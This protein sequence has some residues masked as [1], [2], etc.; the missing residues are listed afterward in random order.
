MHRLCGFARGVT[1]TLAGGK[2][3]A[4]G[5]P[6]AWRFAGTEGGQHGATAR[7][8][9]ILYTWEIDPLSGIDGR[10]RRP[11]HRRRLPAIADG[12]MPEL[13]TVH[14]VEKA[15]TILGGCVNQYPAAM[16]VAFVGV[17]PPA[18]RVGHRVDRGGLGVTVRIAWSVHR[19]QTRQPSVARTVDVH[20]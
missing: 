13:V 14:H 19:V 5:S 10:A 16:P 2:G 7:I 20:R 3:V 17:W 12:V 1:V 18:R 8:G 4:T 15:G 6:V 11:K 9:E